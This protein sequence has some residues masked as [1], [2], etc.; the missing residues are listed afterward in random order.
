MRQFED[1]D[2]TYPDRWDLLGVEQFGV[3][4]PRR[5]AEELRREAGG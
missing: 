4:R 3:A 5:L 1:C 2:E